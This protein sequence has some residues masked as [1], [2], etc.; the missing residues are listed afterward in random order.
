M[1]ALRPLER[2]V[3][4]RVSAAPRCELCG[5]PLGEPHR[6]VIDVEEG[7]VH[8]ACAVCTRIFDTPAGRYRTV[9]TDVRSV[10]GLREEDW[11]SLGIPVG[12]AFFV[13]SSTAGWKTILPSPAGS[14]EAEVPEAAWAALVARADLDSRVRADI[15]AVVVR[16]R[17]GGVVSSCIAPIDV[18]FELMALLRQKWSGF[19]GGENVRVLV[20]SFIGGLMERTK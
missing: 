3:R 13:R 2:F 5:E 11:R 10:E 7:R 19:D 9:P 12:L 15:E 6:H 4:R 14:T 8:C 16:W 17:R 20:E 1:T 18:C